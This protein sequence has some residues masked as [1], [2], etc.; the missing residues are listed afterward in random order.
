MA[1][2]LVRA[3]I[4]DESRGLPHSLLRRRLPDLRRARLQRMG[5][6][7]QSL[8]ETDSAVPGAASRPALER[9]PPDDP[10]VMEGLTRGELPRGAHPVFHRRRLSVG[11][12]P[13]G[14]AVHVRQVRAREIDPRARDGNPRAVSVRGR[15]VGG[16]L[17]R[18][19]RGEPAPAPNAEYRWP[20][21]LVWVVFAFVFFG[22]GVA[23]L[24][25]A[26]LAWATSDTLA[27]YLVQAAIPLAR[28]AGPPLT[29]WGFW[30]ARHAR[31][32]RAIAA[33][34]LV[35][36]LGFPLALLG[37]SLRRVLRARGVSHA[38]RHHGPD[39]AGLQPLPDRVR[40]LG[41]VG[42]HPRPVFAN[43]E[44]CEHSPRRAFPSP[45]CTRGMSSPR[46]GV[47]MTGVASSKDGARA[48]TA[49]GRRTA[50]RT[51]ASG[52]TRSG[53]HPDR[54]LRSRVRARRP[55]R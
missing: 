50:E 41:A 7:L 36:E 28:P 4:A 27:S 45:R 17:I 40:V 16:S 35:I 10:A 55:A 2:V 3:G 20:I 33:A 25:H 14:R 32:G 37:R 18:S 43:A 23:K 54:R 9:A 29:D 47:V 12:L 31:L 34:T 13:P 53:F 42:S 52:G 30:I 49:D 39:P 15:A 48:G 21:R 24:R 5:W 11:D 46:I 22:G 1:A 26:G 51:A 6:R 38:A 8:L 19:R 44:P